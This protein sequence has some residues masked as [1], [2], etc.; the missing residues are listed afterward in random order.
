MS[1]RV[2]AFSG[3]TAFDGSQHRGQQKGTS[4][5]PSNSIHSLA[6]S[7]HYFRPGRRSR[8]TNVPPYF[9]G[10]LLRRRKKTVIMERLLALRGAEPQIKG[11]DPR[12][13]IV[14]T[15]MLLSK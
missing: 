8:P 14:I 10:R 2:T 5:S 6:V 13:E 11:L 7:L 12:K 9:A 15:E 3:D 1:Y 4:D